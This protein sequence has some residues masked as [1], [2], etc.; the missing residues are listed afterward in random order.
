MKLPPPFDGWWLT[1]KAGW[2]VVRAWLWLALVIAACL[3]GRSCG[4]DERAVEVE[5]LKADH[6]QAAAKSAQALA[7]LATDYRNTERRMGQDFIDATA[8]HHEDL[9]RV[10]TNRDALVA[11]LL[12]GAERLQDR[13][14]GAVS[15]TAPT[16][17]PAGAPD[18]AA[19]DRAESAGR[20]VAAAAQCDAQVAGLQSLLI[21]ERTP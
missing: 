9:R 3:Y 15:A 2:L 11:R 1:I 4:R 21:A 20:I 13:W 5:R 18:A 10:Q 16:A 7:Q 6:A 8:R 14:A 19:R 17:G 12:S